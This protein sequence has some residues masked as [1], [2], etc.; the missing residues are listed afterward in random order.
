MTDDSP[1]TRDLPVLHDEARDRGLFD[2]APVGYVL[3]DQSGVI[4]DANQRAEADLG[5]PRARL[6]GRRF[7]TFTRPPHDSTFLLFLRQAFSQPGP[8]RVE[9][10]LVR[11]DGASFHAQVEAWTEGPLCRMTL[12]DVSASRAAQEELLRVN[13]MLERR[14]E[15]QAAQ[16]QVVTQELEAFV[17]A[18]MQQTTG[19]LR[20]I[21][22]FT[23]VA[24]A[25]A[26]GDPAERQRAS[27]RVVE[28]ADGLEASLRALAAFS[29][30]SRQRLKF[31]PVD[32]NV[33]LAQ[34]IRKLSPEWAGRGVQLTRDPLPVIRGDTATVQVILTQLLSNAFKATRAR[35]GGR[36]HVGMREL[37]REVAVYV[38][39]N[40][41]GFNSRYRDRLF[42]IFGHL[43]RPED[44]AGPGLGLALVQRL[45]LRHGGRV[46]A[47]GRPGQ[48][49]TFWVA[50]PRDPAGT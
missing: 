22:A 20:H 16:V 31:M 32:L 13:A 48:G 4:L 2:R 42:T 44:F 40:G 45:A 15:G 25:E 41:I 9:L 7:C 28:A 38:E 50:F 11:P 29:S 17:A 36:I 5:L 30:V 8:Q 10:L 26:D 46:W 24:H 23:Q 34:V 35:E 18:V 49:A 6:Q 47:E 19:P 21:R 33:V 12:T 37:E 14:A 3:L 39:D 1:S 43:H 27:Q